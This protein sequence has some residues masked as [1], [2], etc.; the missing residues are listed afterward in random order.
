MSK[1]FWAFSMVVTLVGVCCAQ[2]MSGRFFPFAAKPQYR[3]IDSTLPAGMNKVILPVIKHIGFAFQRAHLAIV[4]G[5]RHD[6]W[7]GILEIN[8]LVC[9]IGYKLLYLHTNA[10]LKQLRLMRISRSQL[11]NTYYTCLDGRLV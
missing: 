10:D 11:I 5:S 3:F 7:G 9:R 8:K 6:W 2:S 1:T 4:G